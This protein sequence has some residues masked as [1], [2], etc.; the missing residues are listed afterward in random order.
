M[1]T[2]IY[3]V[4]KGKHGKNYL[5]TDVDDNYDIELTQTES[6]RDDYDDDY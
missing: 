1:D 5:T 4:A 6:E 2:F 3:F